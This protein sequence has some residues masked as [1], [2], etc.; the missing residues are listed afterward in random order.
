MKPLSGQLNFLE[1]SGDGLEAIPPRDPNVPEA[2]KPRLSRQSVEIL[3]RLLEGPATNQ[4]LT[5]VSHR[6]GARIYDLRK[7]G[8]AI[9]CYDEDHASGLAWYRLSQEKPHVEGV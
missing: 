1:P 3:K 5:K 6:F 2:A 8:Y 7:A 4:D 9:E